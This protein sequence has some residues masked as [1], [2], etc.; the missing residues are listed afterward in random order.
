MTE[1]SSQMPMGRS[2]VSSSAKSQN[3]SGIDMNDFLKILAASMSNPSLGGESGG[4]SGG[5]DYISQLVQF[6]TLEQIQTLS[7]NVE[8]TMM[9]TQQQQAISMIGKEVKVM[10]GDKT[11]SGKIDKVKFATGFA[12]IEVNGKDYLMSNILELGM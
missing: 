2:S 6:T 11:V 12:T 4:S 1:I 10:D 7:S 8:Y 5:T 3:S 9:M